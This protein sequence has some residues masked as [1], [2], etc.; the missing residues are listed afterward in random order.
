MKILLVDPVGVTFG[1]ASA[2]A[3]LGALLKTKGYS[4]KGLD[5]SDFRG[6]SY[7]R[8]RE[9]IEEYRSDVIGFSVLY[10]NYNWVKKNSK[11]L[12]SFYQGKIVLGGPQIT[13][14]KEMVTR[15]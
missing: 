14:E 7:K 2:L 9:V 12:R 3:Y 4:V 15:I 6:N 1:P 13:A 5:L 10:S 8:E 11:Y